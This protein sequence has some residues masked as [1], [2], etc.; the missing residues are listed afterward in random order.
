MKKI[1]TVLVACVWMHALLS[2]QNHW[3]VGVQ[4]L[5]QRQQFQ[6]TMDASGR[7]WNALPISTEVLAGYQ[8]GPHWQV[9]ASWTFRQAYDLP[10]APQGHLISTTR[11][12]KN[13]EAALHVGYRYHLPGTFSRLQFRSAIGA[14][15]GLGEAHHGY[16]AVKESQSAFI[17][18]AKETVLYNSAFRQGEEYG[19]HSHYW[20]MDIRQGVEYPLGAKWALTLTGSYTMGF[21]KM[22]GLSGTYQ[23]LP[24]APV[25]FQTATRGTRAGV[26]LGLRYTIVNASN[27]PQ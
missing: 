23:I 9:E 24:A 26:G 27:R 2:A 22:G 20:F 3:Q 4:T 12:E 13:T 17:I 1:I 5:I 18:N 8:W 14:R 11:V 6:T 25:D 10:F 19:L 21:Q 7:G 15:L 16:Y